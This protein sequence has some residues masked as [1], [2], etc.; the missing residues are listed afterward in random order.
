MSLGCP[1]AQEFLPQ[2]KGAGDSR[3]SQG[4]LFPFFFSGL[5]FGGW[6]PRRFGVFIW[7]VS[8]SFH[9]SSFI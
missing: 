5:A 9:P 6:R 8:T 3:V 1:W 4:P 7:A 2:D